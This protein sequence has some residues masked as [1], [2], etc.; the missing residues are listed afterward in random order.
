MSEGYAPGDFT[1]PLLKIEASQLDY[2]F[3]GGQAVTT[4]P[5]SA[6]RRS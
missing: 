3:E 1:S 6:R 4:G 2:F 5:R